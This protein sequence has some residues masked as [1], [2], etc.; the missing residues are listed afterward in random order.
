MRSDE[1]ENEEYRIEKLTRSQLVL[2]IRRENLHG[3][4]CESTYYYERPVKNGVLS[5]A[6]GFRASSRR[7]RYRPIHNS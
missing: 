2:V 4:T 1:R 6:D 3:E 7:L 5:A